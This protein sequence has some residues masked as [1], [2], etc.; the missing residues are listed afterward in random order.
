MK[1]SDKFASQIYSNTRYLFLSSVI[2]PPKTLAAQNKNTKIKR[3]EN[4]SDLV[5]QIRPCLAATLAQ[6]RAEPVA[7]AQVGRPVTAQPVRA[8]QFTLLD[9]TMRKK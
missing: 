3:K 8:I 5:S 6:V 4:D 1:F 2:I 9:S 7:E